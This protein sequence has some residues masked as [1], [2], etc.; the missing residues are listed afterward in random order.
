MRRDEDGALQALVL[1][2]ALNGLDSCHGP[3]GRCL[4]RGRVVDSTPVWKD[5]SP[6]PLEPQSL[7]SLP[8]KV[9]HLVCGVPASG[10]HHVCVSLSTSGCVYICMCVFTHMHLCV[11]CSLFL[12]QDVTSGSWLPKPQ[13]LSMREE[14]LR[15]PLDI[16]TVVPERACAAVCLLPVFAA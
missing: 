13:C 11:L 15:H 16:C 14:M 1:H 9:L 4:G 3:G 7:P 2:A 6:L 10:C 5:F 8:P 12:G